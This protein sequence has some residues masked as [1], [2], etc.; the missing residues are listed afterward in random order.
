MQK[1]SLTA[2]GACLVQGPPAPPG[3]VLPGEHPAPTQPLEGRQPGSQG[4]EAEIWGSPSPLCLLF[5]VS[6]WRCSA[7]TDHLEQG[8]S[9][10]KSQ[11]LRNSKAGLRRQLR[12]GEREEEGR[13][14]H[15]P[16]QREKGQS[17]ECKCQA[18]QETPPASLLQTASA[19]REQRIP[20][21]STPRAAEAQSA[22]SCKDL[23]HFTFSCRSERIPRLLPCS[24]TP[25][26]C[27]EGKERGKKGHS[28]TE[29]WVK[30]VRDA[31]V[32]AQRGETRRAEDKRVH[33]WQAR[34]G[35]DGKGGKQRQEGKQRMERDERQQ[36]R[37]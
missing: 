8:W 7:Q 24:E 36:V 10:A 22:T 37:S 13:I 9:T 2:R 1:A 12:P 15:C 34:T 25:R 17:P 26:C 21:C 35:R 27:R 23:M 31:Q 28:C 11:G 19:H 30:A 6:S 14:P 4:E 5:W 18:G 29:P 33:R 16:F 3:L 20:A 32:G